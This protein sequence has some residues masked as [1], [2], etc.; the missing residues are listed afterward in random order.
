MSSGTGTDGER[1]VLVTGAEGPLADA[2]VR[3]IDSPLGVTVRRAR[4][5]DLIP[6]K[7]KDVNAVVILDG[8][9]PR[10]D[11]KMYAAGIRA[12][13]AGLGGRADRVVSV[14]YCPRGEADCK[15]YADE[16]E[17]AE[18]GLAAATNYVCLRTALVVGTPQQPGP[19]DPSLFKGR[20]P[21]VPVPGRGQAKTTPLRVDD[22]AKVVAGALKPNNP[23]GTFELG[24]PETETLTVEQLV[25]KL[26][27]DDVRIAPVPK[28]LNRSDHLP[29]EDAVVEGGAE[30][31]GQFDVG[32]RLISSAWNEQAVAARAQ[33]SGDLNQTAADGYA[34]TRL[35]AWA[36]GWFLTIGVITLVIS[37]RDLF[38]VDDIGIAIAALLL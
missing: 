30:N 18:Q 29:E 28:L 20:R 8:T 24:G 12:V 37:L 5:G 6:E 31:A 16:A 4:R 11:P 36:C 23:T 27:G 17:V 15:R 35:G 9:W 2:V 25:K 19:S 10:P 33:S 32:L 26:N 1:I 34:R 21:A 22:L 38:V 13:T 7:M 14:A 3:E